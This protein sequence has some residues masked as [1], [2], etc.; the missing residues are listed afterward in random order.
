METAVE[1]DIRAL[2][3]VGTAGVAA[4]LGVGRGVPADAEPVRFVLAAP[5]RYRIRGELVTLPQVVGVARRPLH[6]TSTTRP[7]QVAEAA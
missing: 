4:R 2:K 5:R 7:E 1:K 6:S 3:V